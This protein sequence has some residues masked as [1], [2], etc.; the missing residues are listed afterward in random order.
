[1]NRFIILVGCQ[2]KKND[3]ENPLKANIWLGKRLGTS[4]GSIRF[5]LCFRWNLGDRA[6]DCVELE[7]EEL[8]DN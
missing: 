6:L 7:L 1:V 2:V 4:W 8:N 3:L 5:V